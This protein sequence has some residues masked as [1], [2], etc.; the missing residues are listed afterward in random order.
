M[1]K[2]F[3]SRLVKLLLL[4][5]ILTA[6]DTNTADPISSERIRPLGTTYNGD[7]TNY[8]SWFDDLTP[9]DTLVLAAGIYT[10]GLLIDDMNGTA[11]NPIVITGPESGSPAV[12]K[13]RGCCNTVSIRNS[14]YVQIRHLEL[15][16]RDGGGTKLAGV[17][18]VKAESDG[19][20]AHHIT[21]E[22]LTI[23]NHDGDQQTV[24]I[25]T[26]CPAWDWVIRGNIID[27]AGTGMYLGDSD[28]GAP[29]INGLIEGNLVKDTIG[30][31]VQIKHQ[32]GPR[33]TGLGAPADGTTIIRH[34]VFSKAANAATGDDARPNLLVGHWPLSD[35]GSN[36][37]YQIYGNF[38]YQNPS[39]EPLFQG[40]GN[41]ALYDNLFVNNDG[42]AIGIQPHNDVPRLIRVFNNTI[43]A[44]S[45]G[46][47][48]TGGDASQQRVISNA[49]FAATPIDAPMETQSDNISDSFANAGNHLVNPTGSPTGSPS[50]LDL[51]P[52]ANMLQGAVL[53]SSSFNTFQDWDR[54]FNSQQHDGTFRGAYAGEGANPGWLPRLERK[55]LGDIQ[56]GGTVTEAGSGLSGVTFS[57]SGSSCNPSDSSGTYTCFVVSAWSGAL[58]PMKLG[59]IFTPTLVS[60][61]NVTTHTLNQDYLAANTFT[62]RVYLPVVL[63]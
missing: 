7:P 18:A 51:Y 20:W 61:M 36:D 9:G 8:L 45:T 3:V 40:E 42:A 11:G 32:V 47:N 12:F 57:G 5:L 23:Y 34:N 43:V 38:F 1:R 46:L 29:F 27:S 52:L 24:G 53:D 50:Q 54:D 60:Y 56:I 25:S 37:V 19:Q 30:Y 4:V 21:L 44:S 2:D 10:D 48:L 17:D 55:P 22:N 49:V 26:K 59:Y 16:G 63:K 58:T 13:A 14:S 33:P 35:P 41:V 39:G 62:E 6:F 28:G 15:D 31:N